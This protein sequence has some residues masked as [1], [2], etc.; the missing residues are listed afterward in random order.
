MVNDITIPIF[1]G[2]CALSALLLAR[3]SKRDLLKRLAW[4]LLWNWA[5]CNSVT[6]MVGFQRAPLLMPAVDTAMA[7]CVPL[8]A[9]RSVAAS[10]VFGL[11]VTVGIVHV[12]A[13]LTHTEG[14][15]QY[16]LTLNL[17]YLAQV[18]TVGAASGLALLATRPRTRGLV[19]WLHAGH[20]RVDAS[21]RKVGA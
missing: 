20:A 14:R 4:L 3:A 1:Y 2:L 17:L 8:V 12:D 21:E 5:L 18:V 19:P 15:P 16:F 6:V 9:G 11:Y 10:I 13:F 7:L